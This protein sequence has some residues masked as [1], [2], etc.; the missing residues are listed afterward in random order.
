MGARKTTASV[1]KS[2]LTW[3][4]TVFAAASLGTLAFLY[5]EGLF[6]ANFG[7]EIAKVT[8]QLGVLSIAGAIL[9]AAANRH[10]RIVQRNQQAGE[11]CDE[12]LAGVLSRTTAAFNAVK[13]A[14]RLLRART[15]TSAGSSDILIAPAL[16]DQ[17]LDEIIRAQLQIEEIHRDVGTSHPAFD[18]PIATMAHLK[19]MEKY[20]HELI[21]EYEKMRS[22]LP[23]EARERRKISLPRLVDFQAPY[24]ESEFRA[25]L[26]IPYRRLRR[27]LTAEMRHAKLGSR[28]KRRFPLGS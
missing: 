12:V 2:P 27:L 23:E 1:V 19:M 14:R 20:L 16:Y 9:S 13:R 6:P 5:T 4:L 8:L 24:R 25:R 18:D 26:A 7:A 28:A 10:Q 22:E 21:A 11:Y 3:A 15:I 17:L